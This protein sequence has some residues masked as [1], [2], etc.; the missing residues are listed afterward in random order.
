[1]ADFPVGIVVV[2][3]TPENAVASLVHPMAP[4]VTWPPGATVEE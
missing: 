1:M 2:S 4:R 3:N